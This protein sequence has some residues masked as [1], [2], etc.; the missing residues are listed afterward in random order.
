MAAMV[1]VTEARGLI[2]NDTLVS[3]SLVARDELLSGRG[4]VLP[5]VTVPLAAGDLELELTNAD[6]VPY[7]VQLVHDPF[8]DDAATATHVI[9]TPVSRELGGS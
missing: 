2:P 1:R 5:D 9:Q 7:V 4:A 3:S 6:R 8:A